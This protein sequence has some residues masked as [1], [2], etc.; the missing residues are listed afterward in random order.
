MEAERNALSRFTA[1]LMSERIGGTFAGAITGVQKFGVFVRLDETMAEGLVPA[2]TL[3]EPF[4]Y[5]PARQV[6][7]GR[8]SG[9]AL[10]LGDRVAVELTEA[11]VLTGQLTFRLVDH[12]PGAAAR[13]AARPRGKVRT[14]RKPR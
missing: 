10:A 11:D 4:T 13:A 14:R 8:L 5:D 12:T 6:L 9:S 1:L 3:G 7:L 2:R